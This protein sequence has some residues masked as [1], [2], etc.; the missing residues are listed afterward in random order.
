MHS[1]CS[2]PVASLVRPGDSEP[3]IPTVTSPVT[4]PGLG[5]LSWKGRNAFAA[6]DCGLPCTFPL[7]ISLTT[8]RPLAQRELVQLY[9]RNPRAPMPACDTGRPPNLQGPDLPLSRPL[10]SPE[11]S[12]SLPGDHLRDRTAVI[13]ERRRPLMRPPRTDEGSV[14]P[15][16]AFHTPAFPTTHPVV[17][18][19]F[20]LFPRTRLWTD[21]VVVLVPRT[22]YSQIEGRGISRC[23]LS[24]PN[25]D[26]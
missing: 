10:W 8:T 25:L 3:R 4:T 18:N 26:K 6:L 23:T 21:L 24:M 7:G 12:H 13:G 1:D 22:N 17:Q 5:C 15:F 16:H 11:L 14:R 19:D 20:G 2:L 9:E